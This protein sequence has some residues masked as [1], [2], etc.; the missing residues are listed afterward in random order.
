MKKNSNRRPLLCIHVE[1][2]IFLLPVPTI[3]A[4][5]PLCKAIKEAFLYNMV[6]T[7]GKDA[8]KMLLSEIVSRLELDQ[9]LLVK[10]TGRPCHMTYL[11]TSVILDTQIKSSECSD[12][13]TTTAEE[14]SPEA[15]ICKNPRSLFSSETPVTRSK[16]ATVSPS[17]SDASEPKEQ[18][19]KLSTSD[20]LVFSRSGIEEPIKTSLVVSLKSGNNQSDGSILAE[21]CS[22]LPYQFGRCFGLLINSSK[23]QIYSVSEDRTEGIVKM[24]SY[25]ANVFRRE[26]STFDI[27]AFFKLICEVASILLDVQITH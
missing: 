25:K 18:K 14:G 1:C 24:F 27:E 9:S 21:L 6:D 2:P 3:A 15:S 17:S 16:N 26:G 23:G 5:T 7:V 19:P 4:E 12:T 22:R 13:D 10:Q 20:I 8:I 11:A